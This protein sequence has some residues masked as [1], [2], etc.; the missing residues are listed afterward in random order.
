MAGGNGWSQRR[1]AR[2]GAFSG[3]AVSGAS[4]GR[5]RCA[6]WFSASA[7]A[8]RA[9]AAFRRST[10]S[11]RERLARVG[12]GCTARRCRDPVV[13]DAAS[14]RP[15]TRKL[16]RWPASA[17]VRWK[18]SVQRLSRHKLTLTKPRS[19]RQVA[20]SPTPC[21]STAKWRP[22]G[23]WRTPSD[24]IGSVSRRSD[25]KGRALAIPTAGSSPVDASA[26]ERSVLLTLAPNRRLPLLEARARAA[27]RCR[28][29]GAAGAGHLDGGASGWPPRD[30]SGPSWADCP[31]G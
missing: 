24:C 27:L 26:K 16:M 10:S 14:A 25:E 19:S 31:G 29:G 17:G 7:A 18:V 5:M 8:R 4:Q 22:V 20:R 28:L 15:P 21:S 6:M 13:A 12:S 3:S 11:A 9:S 2:S 1:R 30:P 23:S